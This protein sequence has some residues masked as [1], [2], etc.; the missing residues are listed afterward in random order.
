MQG[1]CLP[2]DFRASEPQGASFYRIVKH[3]FVIQMSDDDGEARIP[4]M[5]F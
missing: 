4:A 2:N 3:P 5:V 1:F